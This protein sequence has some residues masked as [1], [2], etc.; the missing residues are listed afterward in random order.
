M[1]S[2]LDV[3]FLT[4]AYVSSL[5]LIHLDLSATYLWFAYR[6]SAK[7]SRCLCLWIVVPVCRLTPP[8]SFVLTAPF[9]FSPL[10][11]KGQNILNFEIML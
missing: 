9:W 3:V 7:A 2:V 11:P 5:I 4:A 8:E 6:D 1:V 10:N